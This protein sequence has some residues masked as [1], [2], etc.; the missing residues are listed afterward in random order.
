MR[1]MRRLRSYQDMSEI[2]IDSKEVREYFENLNTYRLAVVM[3]AIFWH[4][5]NCLMY[6]QDY[7][8]FLLKKQSSGLSKEI[9]I[10]KKLM[11]YCNTQRRYL[12]MASLYACWLQ[13][14]GVSMFNNITE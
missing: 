9:F 13:N 4:K 3:T 1:N 8:Q 12:E 5:G 6:C 14:T 10:N 2:L 7:S 11:Q